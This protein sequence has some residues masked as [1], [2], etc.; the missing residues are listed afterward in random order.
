MVAVARV[1]SVDDEEFIAETIRRV[2]S[3]DQE[4]HYAG[5][6][7]SADQLIRHLQQSPANLVVLDLNMPGKDAFEAIEEVRRLNPAIRVVVL[8]GDR[9][10]S[11]V[12]RAL[13]AGAVGYISKDEPLDVLL[14]ELRRAA[15][16]QHVL[17]P[18]VKE[19]VGRLSRFG[20]F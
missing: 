10:P 4:L 15:Q 20:Q 16:G 14:A 3:N 5:S 18:Q 6:L 8:S 2:L 7:P 12:R 1:L 19:S 11:L 9:D 17:S 13:D